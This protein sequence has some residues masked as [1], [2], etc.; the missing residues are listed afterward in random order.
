MRAQVSLIFSAVSLMG[1]Q[2]YTTMISGPD[3]VT[4]QQGGAKCGSRY[5]AHMYSPFQGVR[6]S[7]EDVPPYVMA[8]GAPLGTARPQHVCR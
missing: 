2:R 3:D 6:V 5:G 7:G 4:L 8:A 1:S